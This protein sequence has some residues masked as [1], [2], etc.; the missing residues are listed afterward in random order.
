GVFVGLENGLEGLLHISELSDQK[1]DNPQ[2]VV[3]EGEEIEVKVL[4][5]D[6]DERKIGLSRKRVEWADEDALEEVGSAD[7]SG[8]EGKKSSSALKGGIGD[9]SGPL[10]QTSVEP[11][12]TAVEEA[13]AEEPAAE[14]AAAEEPAAEE[15]AAEEPAAEEAAAEEATAEEAAAEEAT[16]E[17]ATAEE[18]TGA[19]AESDDAD[20][21][22]ES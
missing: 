3:K 16:A 13:A 2:D 9:A 19:D 15:P 10:I 5:V 20:K 4:R 11:E 8:I 18:A 1:V 14:E 17:E 7:D 22:E 21:N 12:E 6:T